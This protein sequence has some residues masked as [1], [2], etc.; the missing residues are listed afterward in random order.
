M[1]TVYPTKYGQHLRLLANI[2]DQHRNIIILTAF[3]GV[4][5]PPEGSEATVPLGI[6]G[7]LRYDGCGLCDLS[8][9]EIE[10]LL[11]SSYHQ[12]G[13]QAKCW[14]MMW[15]VGI[16]MRNDEM[17]W[18]CSI[19]IQHLRQSG[20][21]GCFWVIFTII[22]CFSVLLGC[23]ISLLS[24]SWHL[25]A[26]KLTYH[27]KN[28]GWKTLFLFEMVPFQWRFVHFRGGW[29]SPGSRPSKKL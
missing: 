28:A 7:S 27:L 8:S 24:V 29:V 17:I 6:W 12:E 13:W 20:N 23:T 18:W 5:T 9:L 14:K 19:S 1:Y 11:P 4:S 25:L 3:L 16:L 22:R 26:R 15:R 21:P 10:D 2:L